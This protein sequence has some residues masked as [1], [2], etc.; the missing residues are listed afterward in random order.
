MEI[1]AALEF[2]RGNNHAVLST[3]RRNG[4]PQLSP[5]TVGLDPEHPTGAVVISSRQT[6]VKVKNLQRDPRAWLAVFTPQF[7]GEW[8]Q[9][10]GPV[11]IVP[12]PAAM[13]ILVE[14]YRAI[15]GEHPDWDDYRAAMVREQRC[16]IRIRVES[17]GPTVSG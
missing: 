7:Y 5:V 12:L 10:A 1:S 3:M 16:I 8:V 15:S 6:A 17:V 11:D 2:V 9:L 14:Y 13:P 4:T